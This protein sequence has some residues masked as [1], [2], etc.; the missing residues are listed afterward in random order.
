LVERRE[1]AYPRRAN[2][3]TDDKRS[4]RCAGMFAFHFMRAFP[5]E[6]RQMTPEKTGLFLTFG[7]MGNT[8]AVKR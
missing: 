3:S 8:L 5:F 7:K 1:P 6:N 2:G 4:L